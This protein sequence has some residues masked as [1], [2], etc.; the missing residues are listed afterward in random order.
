MRKSG[1]RYTTAASYA[2]AFVIVIV[3]QNN[4]EYIYERVGTQVCVNLIYV[5]NDAVLVD[6]FLVVL[7]VVTDCETGYKGAEQFIR[8]VVVNV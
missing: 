6:L 7:R 1:Y 3:E 5:R 8:L 2:N 4:L